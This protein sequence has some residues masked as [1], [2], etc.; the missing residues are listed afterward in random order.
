VFSYA[1]ASGFKPFA[2]VRY[3]AAEE[4]RHVVIE[5]VIE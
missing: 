5:F 2:H 4:A 3:D 1:S